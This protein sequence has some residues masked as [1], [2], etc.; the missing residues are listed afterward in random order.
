[1]AAGYFINGES[2][3][4]VKGPSGSSISSLSTLGVTDSPIHVSPTLHHDD[5]HTDPTGPSVPPDLQVFGGEAYIRMTMIYF[6]VAVLDACVA[7]AQAGST[8]GTLAR[9]GILMGGSAARLAAGNNYIG[10]NISSPVG[11]RPWR[12][13]TAYL[14]REPFSWPLGTGRSAVALTWRAI[15]YVLNPISGLAGAVLWDRSADS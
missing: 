11:G 4:T 12:F 15:P 14:A 8:A 1:M 6:D 7:L 5:I 13:L 9:A 3:V 2:L 10:L